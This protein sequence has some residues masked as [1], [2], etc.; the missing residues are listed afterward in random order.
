MTLERS[1]NAK[2]AAIQALFFMGICT[3]LSYAAVYLGAI[4]LSS[5]VIGVIMALGNLGATILQP[6]LAGFV[7][8]KNLN[9]NHVVMA[10]L[11]GVSVICVLMLLFTKVNAV[12]AVLY[13]L[14]MTFACALTP[15]LNV[16]TFRFEQYG[17]QLSYGVARGIGSAA[18]ALTSLII[19]N[20]LKVVAAEFV[21]LFMIIAFVGLIPIL[22][23]FVVKDREI[24]N[25]QPAE[26]EEDSAE[27]SKINYIAFAKRYP[28]FM[29]FVAGTI[30]I[31][32]THMLINNFFI[33]FVT[34]VGGTTG[35][36]GT[37][38]FLAAIVELPA[39]V[40]FDKFK[41][42]IDI[43]LLLKAAAV[44]YSIKHFLM[45][46]ATNMILIDI[47]ML[48]QF[49]SYAFLVPASVYYAAR[50]IDK[51]DATKGQALVTM[52][53]TIGG[54]FASLFG[55]VL[56]DGVGVKMTLVI[57]V[58]ISIIGTLLVVLFSEK[59][60]SETE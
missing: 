43:S 37:A 60:V 46:I 57:G 23:G 13:T 59:P 49:L 8:E 44:F 32:F 12:V 21:P 51:K 6:V 17:I 7:D 48:F 3:L 5:S 4:G 40:V 34:N 30:L 38:L 24:V 45:L 33:N 35:D 14:T 29:I 11:A 2:Y 1:L 42:K 58:V 56:L 26:T 27:D 53:S 28:K 15:L 16:M 18:Y 41:E 39:M 9:V 22:N 20:I 36:M 19:G 55:G 47:S 50:V 54:I 52:G 25:P 10:S 31:F